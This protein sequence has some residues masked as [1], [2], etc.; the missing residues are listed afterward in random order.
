[1][2]V[3]LDLMPNLV[4]GSNLVASAVLVDEEHFLSQVI[5]ELFYSHQI[6]I[7][8]LDSFQCEQYDA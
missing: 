3:P 6:D 1:V 2:I 5:N 7:R 4:R 8:H